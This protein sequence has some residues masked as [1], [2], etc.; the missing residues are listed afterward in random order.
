MK[1]NGERMDLDEL[2]WLTEQ[3]SMAMNMTE[4]VGIQDRW[5][6][7]LSFMSWSISTK[8]PSSGPSTPGRNREPVWRP[9]RWELCCLPE[10]HTHNSRWHNGLYDHTYLRSNHAGQTAVHTWH[11]HTHTHLKQDTGK[12]TTHWITG[13]LQIMQ[14]LLVN[15]L[16]KFLPI[17]KCGYYSLNCRGHSQLCRVVITLWIAG[18]TPNYA[19]WL[20]L[21][22]LQGSLPIMQCGY[23]S[24]TCRG[25]SQLCSVV[26]TLW[27]AGVTP[28]YAVWLLLTELQ[29]SL[30]IMQY[31]Y[32]S[33]NYRGH[34]QLWSMVIILWIADYD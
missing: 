32:Y 2:P 17:M 9:S 22:E 31:G 29:G 4:Q 30:P 18:V 27:I 12:I 24:L 25:H 8:L 5:K 10:A 11:T 19:E 33:L 14:C 21:S 23:Y 15:E 7:T 26:I 1:E 20:L 28:N 3:V 16:Q 6:E 13:V 34:S